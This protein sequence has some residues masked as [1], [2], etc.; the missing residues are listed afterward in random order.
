[1]PSV[2]PRHC[3]ELG[4]NPAPQQHGTNSCCY[5]K[6]KEPRKLLWCWGAWTT[7]I[8]A[9]Y[10]S[11]WSAEQICSDC[12]YTEKKCTP[13]CSSPPFGEKKQHE[14]EKRKD[15]RKDRRKRSYLAKVIKKE[16][17]TCML[18]QCQRYHISAL[19]P[20]CFVLMGKCK[21]TLFPGSHSNHCLTA[22]VNSRRQEEN[23]LTCSP[24]DTKAYLEH[25]ATRGSPQLRSHFELH[26][27]ALIYKFLYL[28]EEG[29]FYLTLLFL[30]SGHGKVK[31]KQSGSALSWPKPK[32][33]ML[34]A[35]A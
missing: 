19:M 2:I 11:A 22:N 1:M 17:C 7:Q 10:P 9:E 20:I 5:I 31:Q 16:I 27:L 28:I 26:L 35:R 23:H 25:H 32:P 14:Q 6:T 33:T 13:R 30:L 34:Q 15:G 21:F 4:K 29:A 3:S 12:A 24:Q 18:F 8:Q